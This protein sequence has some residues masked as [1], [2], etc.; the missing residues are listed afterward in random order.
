M[1]A[2]FG[3]RILETTT[4]TGTGNLTMAGAVTTYQTFDSKCTAD[5]D[6]HPFALA[7]GTQWE[8]GVLTRV[9]AGVYSRTVTANSSG[10]TSPLTLAV[11]T[12]EVWGDVPA[13]LLEFLNQIE[14]AVASAPT[15]DIGAAPSGRVQITGTT[16]I[17]S[18]GTQ[19]NKLRIVRFAGAAALTLTHNATSLILPGQA[20]ISAL[21]GDVG[22]FQSD[23]AGN[24][25]C[26]SFT[27]LFD[28]P[29][30]RGYLSGL[31]LSNN[32]GTPNTKIDVTAGQ[33]REDTNSAT[34]V[35]AAGTLDCGTVGANGL[36]SGSLANNTWYHVWA[37]A[38]AD[39]TTARF[40][41]TSLG[42]ALPSGYIYKRR[43]GSFKTDGS[44]HI[45][46]FSQKGDEFLWLAGAAPGF[47]SNDEF[48]TMTLGTTATLFTVSVPIGVQVI[49][50]LRFY[51]I[52]TGAQAILIN[53]PDE[54]SVAGGSMG[55]NA[56]AQ[57]PTGVAFIGTTSIRTDTSGRVR[58][59]ASAAS[60]TLRGGA[61]GWLDR[62]GRDD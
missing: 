3:D 2:R 23:A 13:A 60:M 40:A 25:R 61:Y 17:T 19:P 10:T 5:G 15:C 12:K 47:T 52:H 29:V 30:A 32:V 43:I 26:I 37:I 14:N 20:N 21:P 62:R 31:Q 11:G 24:W 33:C 41:S 28:V 1:T 50:L 38:K 36:E 54:T 39:G 45:W 6:T 9:S 53:S 27:R 22:I 57:N 7:G 55:F 42:P 34:L 4:T 58:V 49:A 44:A 48:N 8:V 51:I 56:T 35:L 59:V 16:T 18:F 46:A